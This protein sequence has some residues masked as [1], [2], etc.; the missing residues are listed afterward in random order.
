MRLVDAPDQSELTGV[1]VCSGE[2]PDFGQSSDLGQV[3]AE[4][5]STNS[6]VIVATSTSRSPDCAR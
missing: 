1:V 5:A 2:S 3:L 4:T 6:H